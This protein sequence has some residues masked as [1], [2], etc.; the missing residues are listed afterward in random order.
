M[1]LSPDARV[2]LSSA[3]ALRNLQTILPPPAW[4][5]LCAAVAVASSERL[6]ALARAAGFARVCVAA[7]AGSADLLAVAAHCRPG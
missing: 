6:A 5:R 2:L 1:R 3:E 4:T 7:S